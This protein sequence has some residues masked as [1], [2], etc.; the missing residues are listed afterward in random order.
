MTGWVRGKPRDSHQ[1]VPCLSCMQRKKGGGREEGRRQE[2]RR[3][4]KGEGEE[5]E[6]ERRRE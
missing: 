1:A 2:G 6:E 3:E 5:G 4:G